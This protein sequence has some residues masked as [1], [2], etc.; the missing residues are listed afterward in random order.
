MPWLL[1]LLLKVESLAPSSLLAMLPLLLLPLLSDGFL[2]PL[3]LKVESL[4]P[5]WLL[6]LFLLELKGLALKMLPLAPLLL[7]AL[8]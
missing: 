2:L 4:A 5:P 1:L 3:L 6:V 7:L 8:F